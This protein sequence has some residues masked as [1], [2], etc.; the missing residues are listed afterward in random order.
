M[1][2]KEMSLTELCG[3]YASRIRAGDFD[4]EKIKRI[5]GEQWDNEADSGKI[6]WLTNVKIT[7]SEKIHPMWWQVS[8]QAEWDGPGGE[9]FGS[10][11]FFLVDYV[12]AVMDSP[13]INTAAEHLGEIADNFGSEPWPLMLMRDEASPHYAECLEMNETISDD[14]RV[15]LAM[16]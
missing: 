3:V 12:A 14:L 15:W 8:F 7:G 6:R 13:D 16:R 5:A 10:G 1:M 4:I 2:E 11:N 9:M